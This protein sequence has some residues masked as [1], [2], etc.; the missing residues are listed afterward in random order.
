MSTDNYCYLVIDELD[1]TGVLIDPA[2]PDAV[3]V[4]SLDSSEAA[5]P[6]FHTHLILSCSKVN[7]AAWF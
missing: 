3:Q 4:K 2:D 6:L 5:I 7:R 1:K